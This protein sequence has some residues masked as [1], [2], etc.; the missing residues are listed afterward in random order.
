MMRCW[1]LREKKSMYRQLR[2]NLKEIGQVGIEMVEMKEGVDDIAVISCC[3]KTGGAQSQLV[4]ASTAMAAGFG[5]KTALNGF[6]RIGR[7]MLRC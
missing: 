1:L 2:K 7:T 6:G 4:C 3:P 5:T